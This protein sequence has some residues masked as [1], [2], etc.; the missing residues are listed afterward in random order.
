VLS[1]LFPL[2]TLLSVALPSIQVK[3]QIGLVLANSLTAIKNDFDTDNF[4]TEYDTDHSNSEDENSKQS[5]KQK[6]S[7]KN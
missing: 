4:Y 7:E 5:K 1:L 3:G 6:T 2:V